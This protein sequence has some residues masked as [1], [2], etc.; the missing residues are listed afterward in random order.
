MNGLLRHG[1]LLAAAA[2]L[3]ATAA[4]A[5][6]PARQRA[7]T[8]SPTLPL[9]EKIVVARDLPYGEDAAQ[10][11]DVYRP[12]EARGAP[13]L[14]M[15]HGGGWQRGSRKNA[16]VV[17]NKAAHWLPQGY[18]FVSV[19]YRLLP[20]AGP[21]DQAADVAAALAKVQREAPEWGGDPDK[22][23]LM[24]HSAGAHL[25]ALLAARP[26]FVS[27]AGA[28]PWK[29]TI[30]L[31]SAAYDVGVIMS[32]PH[33]PLYDPVFGKDRRLWEE[34]SPTRKLAEKTAPMLLVCSTKRVVSC[35][36]AKAFARRA[37]SLGGRADVLEVD[38]THMEIN[39]DLGL[40]SA[41]TSD[42][43]A[44]VASLDSAR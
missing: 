38:M 37:Q 2:A 12:P 33:E 3:A 4:A 22:I 39:R 41:Y 30:A 10:R 8:A 42:V 31:D 28:K 32:R 6:P 34:A 21:L 20:D 11:I 35:N 19:D 27:A 40:P 14:V 23:I 25:V 36:Q 5:Q 44:F 7:E 15:V 26:D 16:G 29:A 24:G 9:P 1:A 18:I 13:V 17:A 43:D